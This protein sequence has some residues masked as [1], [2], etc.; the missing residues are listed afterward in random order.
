MEQFEKMH[1][2]YLPK[3]DRR[4]VI[5]LFTRLRQN[6]NS[7]PI[8]TIETFLEKGAN[9]EEI[10]K[11]IIRMTEMVPQ[12]FDKGTHIVVH[13][14]MDYDLLKYINDHPHVIEIKGS[15]AGSMTSIGAS[16]E[17][18]EDIHSREGY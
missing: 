9:T 7:K 6:P 15:Y 12:F 5:D 3:V 14:K 2:K 1:Q 18:S 8:Y 11:E 10:R 4:L 13:H 16:Y 17:S